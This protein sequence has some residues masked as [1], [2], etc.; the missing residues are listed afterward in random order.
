M[1]HVPSRHQPGTIILASAA[2]PR[3]FEF[4]A[5]ME[6]LKVPAGTRYFIERGCD[7]T[8]NFN[9]GL[10]KM[11]G[12]WAWFL[13]DDHKF[14]E[15]TLLRFLDHDVDVVVP[16]S[17][18][19]IAPWAPCVMHGPTDGRVWH[20]DMPLYTWNELSGRGL[21]ELPKGDFIG[22]AGMLVRKP[23]LD[24]V[25]YPWFKCGQFDPGRLQEDIHFCKTVQDLGYTIWVDQDVIFDHW[26]IMG[27]TAR[28]HE[29]QYVPALQSGKHIVVLPDA[30]GIKEVSRGE[31]TPR[32]TWRVPTSLE[33]QPA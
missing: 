32:V 14:D 24:A 21:F 29:G 17:P 3:F 25:G 10:K 7:V 2:Q 11:E 22:Q 15:E 5:S 4:A 6:R 20:E 27:V 12:A 8:A 16:I 9:A 30:K 23:V 1:I 33:D 26:F 28:R 19:K 13:G 31:G 18:T